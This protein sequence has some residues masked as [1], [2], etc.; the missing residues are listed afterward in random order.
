MCGEVAAIGVREV[1]KQICSDAHT[2]LSFDNTAPLSKNAV[3]AFPISYKLLS[4][5]L[6]DT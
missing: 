6:E 3:S 2:D 1:E 4:S 5:T